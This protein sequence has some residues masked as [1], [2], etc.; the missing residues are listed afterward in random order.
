[1]GAGNDLV[2]ALAIDDDDNIYI[3]GETV[4]TDY[5]T[6]VGAYDRT[7]NGASD[8]FVMKINAPDNSSQTTVLNVTVP[9]NS[10]AGAEKFVAQIQ[11]GDTVKIDN[12]G[13]TVNFNTQASPTCTGSGVVYNVNANGLLRSTFEEP[14]QQLCYDEPCTDPLTAANNGHAGLYIMRGAAKT[15]IGLSGTVFT[16]TAD[17][18]LYLGVNDCSGAGSGAPNSGSFTARVTITPASTQTTVLNVTVP[19]N[20]VPNAEKFVTQL[21]AG[22]AVTIDNIGGQVTF[23][24]I[25]GTNGCI[26]NVN[27]N[28]LDRALYNDNSVV[29]Y[30]SSYSPNDPLRGAGEGHAGLY[31]MRGT[32]KTFVG[33]SRKT[34]TVTA[35]QP[36][37]LGV[38]DADSAPNTGSFNA[39]VTVVHPATTTLNV[40]VPG[41]AVKDA[42]KFVTQLN[43]GD[44]VTI[45]NIGGQVNFDSLDNTNNCPYVVNANGLDRAIYNDNNNVLFCYYS[46][47]TPNDPLQGANN[48]HAGLY[49]MRGAQKTFIGLSGATFTAAADQPLYLGVN[50]VGNFNGA[51]TAPNS[52]SFNAIVTINRAATVEPT[53]SADTVGVLEGNSGTKN[54][55]FTVSLS[56]ASDQTVTVRYQTANGTATAGTDYAATGGTL[57]FAPGET[58][59]TVNVPVIGDTLDEPAEYFT[60]QLINPTGAQTVIPRGRANI[61]DDDAVP[62]IGITDATVTEG[63]S[64]TTGA[65]FNVSLSNLS[66]NIVTVN[67]ATSNGTATTPTDYTATSGTLTFAPGTTSKI[68]TVPIIGD[69]IVEPNET[70]NVNLSSA[71]NA[72]IADALGIGIITNDDACSYSLSSAS[73]SVPANGANGSFGVIAQTGCAWTAGTTVGWITVTGG[74]SGGGN[75]AVTFTVAANTGA[76]RTGTIIAAGLTFTVTQAGATSTTNKAFDF[77]GDNKTDIGIFRPNVGEWWIQRSS[78]QQTFALQFGTSTDKIAPAD[79]TGD[80]KT[81]IAFWRPSN[82]FW[83]VLRSEDYSFYSFPF[84]TNGDIPVPADYDAD[85]KADAAVFRPS[86]AT[87]Y[88]NKSSGGTIIQQFGANGD[89]PAVA[90]Y[91]GDGKSDIAIWRPSVGQWWIQ[92]STAGTIAFTFGNSN[93]KPVEGDYTGDGKADVAIFRPATGEWFVLRS[94]NQSYYSFLFG[95]STDIPAPGDYDGDG[96]FDATVFRPSNNTW[97]VQR[98]TAGTLIQSFGQSGDKPVPNAFVP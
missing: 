65:T 15:F 49:M 73:Q 34:F 92:R 32:T 18:P 16:A 44:Q 68:I 52:G 69:T 60:L 45:N 75:G 39:R 10:V 26:Y 80:G 5:P 22:D 8:G 24:S 12:I 2:A 79:F 78:N 9:G 95:I 3:A 97:F 7:F 30:N 90:D 17:Q 74:A 56:P 25:D 47:W 46:E 63:N 35:D 96:R 6:T 31:M 94:E 40:N 53:L 88:I 71:T 29:C 85:G 61:T 42:E 27:S 43:A 57:T 19:G 21:Q 82:G 64:G 70:F 72:T 93:D 37:Y 36:L 66:G 84:G 20:S 13:G 81:D 38:N 59:K 51:A 23:S 62:A 86:T 87:W 1:G 11:A 58:S 33:S 4:S 55:T 98:S 28:G 14:S 89:I 83:F 50:D 76:A 41:N 67:Y 54:A 48:G 77:D 91:D